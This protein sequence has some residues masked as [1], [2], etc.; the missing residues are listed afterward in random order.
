MRYHLWQIWDEAGRC[1]CFGLRA[2]STST[3]SRTDWLQR[4][5]EAYS[6]CK[7]STRESCAHPCPV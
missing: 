1:F 5:H 7:V 3:F 2:A 6:G 4:T